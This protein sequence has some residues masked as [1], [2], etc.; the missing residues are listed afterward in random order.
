MIKE[1][2]KENQEIITILGSTI[3]FL[4]GAALL[5]V[6]FRRYDAADLK[7]EV[8]AYATLGVLLMAWANAKQMKVKV[9]A[10]GLEAEI[11]K[12]EAAIADATADVRGLCE[13]V[14]ELKR[15]TGF[16]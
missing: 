10:E 7:W 4:A 3:T 14:R 11:V 1:W 13:A 15:G 12:L 8:I 6:V 16:S 2:V 9:S 5:I